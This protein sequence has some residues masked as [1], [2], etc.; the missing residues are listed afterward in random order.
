MKSELAQWGPISCGIQATPKFDTTYN[1]GIYSEHLDSIEINHEISVIGYGVTEEGQEYWIGRNSW[2]TYWGEYGFFRMQMYT[3]NL[4]I[5]QDCT[6]GVP[7][8]QPNL[9]VELIQ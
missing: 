4:G 3:D 8:Y 2:G 7:S 9:D 1:G 5:E 6:A